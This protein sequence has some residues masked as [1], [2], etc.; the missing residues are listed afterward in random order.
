MAI[1]KCMQRLAMGLVVLTVTG[2]GAVAEDF[3]KSDIEGIVRDYLIANPEI[4]QEAM[5]ALEKKRRDAED[6]ARATTIQNQSGILFN[7]VHQSE[8]GNPKGDVTIVEFFDYNCSFC[9]RALPDM[10]RLLEED[11]ELRIV[12][13]EFPV[14]GQGSVE[15]AQVSVAVQQLDPKKYLDF[16]ATLIS[17]RGQANKAS[18]LDVA[19]QVGFVRADVEKRIEE[20]GINIPIEEVYALANGLGL[21]GTPSYVIGDE[22]IMG[23]VGYDA[24][25]EKVQAFRQCG[26]TTC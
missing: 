5:V 23:A 13:K 4:I 2:F 20:D 18:A 24:L 7:S 9:K 14:L 15:A 19:E 1:M 17:R 21:T 8:L 22:V 3:T 6:V 25:K 26:E 16:H 11:S 12:M 10:M